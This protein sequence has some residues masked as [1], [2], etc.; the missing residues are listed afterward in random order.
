MVFL[1]AYVLKDYIY[2]SNLL[3]AKIASLLVQILKS[4]LLYHW[5]SFCP[6]HSFDLTVKLFLFAYFRRDEIEQWLNVGFFWCV[7]VALCNK[8]YEW[9]TS[10]RR[11]GHLQCKGALSLGFILLKW[12]LHCHVILRPFCKFC[13]NAKFL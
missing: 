5:L 8:T 2:I 11:L 12:V 6:L 3:S 9:D 1:F 4:Q 7:R 10:P 13:S